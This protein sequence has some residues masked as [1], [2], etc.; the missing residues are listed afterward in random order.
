MQS[1]T[2]L[3]DD[4]LLCILNFVPD[5]YTFLSLLSTCSRLRDVASSELESRWCSFYANRFHFSEFELATVHSGLN[6]RAMLQERM[7]KLLALKQQMLEHAMQL[8]APNGG[9]AAVAIVGGGG[10]GSVVLSHGRGPGEATVSKQNPA[11]TLEALRSVLVQLTEY[12][13]MAT[14]PLEV[15]VE[16]IRMLLRMIEGKGALMANAVRFRALLH[17]DGLDIMASALAY[18]TKLGPAYSEAQRLV[19]GVFFVVEMTSDLNPRPSRPIG[20]ILP[21]RHQ[22]VDSCK[23]DNQRLALSLLAKYNQ[24]E[25]TLNKFLPTFNLVAP[26][27]PWL[28]D[29]AAPAVACSASI[30]CSLETAEGHHMVRAIPRISERIVQLLSWTSNTGVISSCLALVTVLDATELVALDVI[31]ILTRLVRVYYNFGLEG[32]ILMCLLSLA[33]LVL[34]PA[35]TPILTSTDILSELISILK[36][37]GGETRHRHTIKAI[38]AVIRKLFPPHQPEH[39]ANAFAKQFRALSGPA[40]F[41]ELINEMDHTRRVSSQVMLEQLIQLTQPA[42]SST[43]SGNLMDLDGLGSLHGAL[44]PV[45]VP[46]PLDHLD[47]VELLYTTLNSASSDLLNE[48]NLDQSERLEPLIGDLLWVPFTIL[49]HSNVTNLLYSCLEY[50]S[51]LTFAL[52]LSPIHQTHIG[53]TLLH[54]VQLFNPSCATTHSLISTHRPQNH[55]PGSEL[56]AYCLKIA[57]ALI[58]QSELLHDVSQSFAETLVHF[59][60]GKR[61]SAQTFDPA[62]LSSLMAFTIHATCRGGIETAVL[63]IVHQLVSIQL[64]DIQDLGLELEYAMLQALVW[65]KCEPTNATIKVPEFIIPQTPLRHWISLQP[66]I[67]I[68]ENHQPDVALIGLLGLASF[69]STPKGRH[70]VS[71]FISD[72]QSSIH[73]A[74]SRSISNSIFWKRVTDLASLFPDR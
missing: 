16:Q 70:L 31:P 38:L 23:P 18:L 7:A 58:Q 39:V 26:L 67:P 71:T 61:H 69:V 68:L 27:A 63:N 21:L 2:D 40:I 64:D 48:A 42:Q 19:M 24:H 54:L 62:V 13:G 51:T 73:L 56:L 49:H 25:E 57:T 29:N 3:N 47:L 74:Q 14:R 72:H 41:Q 35:A 11:M 22:L 50:L 30:L 6:W 12:E 44:I 15:L 45:H 4:E 60:L 43:G 66:I 28:F 37:L 46:E 32:F 65:S 53:N 36:T 10:A 5:A 20:L 8:P 33:D 17:F 1:L 9:I 52:P 59:V 34:S 55:P